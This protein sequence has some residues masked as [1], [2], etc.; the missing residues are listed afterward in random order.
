[1]SIQFCTQETER[2]HQLHLAIILD[3]F[4]IR[5]GASQFLDH[6]HWLTSNKLMNCQDSSA[7]ES[8][9]VSSSSL[10]INPKIV[11]Y[12]DSSIKPAKNARQQLKVFVY[13]L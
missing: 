4:A 10:G 9:S 5:F 2:M 11:V 8:T 7:L 1:M 3:L 13:E 12:N 6:Y